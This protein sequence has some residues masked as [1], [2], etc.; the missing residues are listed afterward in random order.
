MIDP[1]AVAVD[2]RLGP[3]QYRYVL[4]RA[5]WTGHIRHAGH[6]FSFLAENVIQVWE[7]ADERQEWLLDRRVTGRRIWLEGSP[8]QL[9]KAGGSPD[10]RWPTGRWRA[11][12]GDFFAAGSGQQPGPQEDCWQI[13]NPHFMGGLPRDP[14]QLYARLRA[15]SPDDRPGYAGPF[16]YAADALRSGR[17]PADLRA[18]LYRALSLLPGIEITETQDQN[19]APRISLA[20]DDGARRNEIFIDP[21]NGQF[22]G[23]RT[24]LTCDTRGLKTGTVTTS[25]TVSVAIVGAMDQVPAGDPPTTS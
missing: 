9:A 5:W 25:T 8:E 19:G 11:P 23:E 3:G 21:D 6:D 18:A 20:I 4:T 1:A 7:P 22:A 16:V 2:D 13:P 10:A 12:Y 15:D 17:V 24:T 14:G